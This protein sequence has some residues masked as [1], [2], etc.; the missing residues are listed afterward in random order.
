MCIC[1]FKVQFFFKLNKNLPTSFKMTYV[2][3]IWIMILL[4][5]S[6]TD[7]SSHRLAPNC[8]RSV[9][10]PK[11]VF[12]SSIRGFTTMRY[13][14]LRFTY[15]LTYRTRFMEKML[16]KKRRIAINFYKSICILNT[17]YFDVFCIFYNYI[18]LK[19]IYPALHSK[20]RRIDFSAFD[21]YIL[22]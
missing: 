11:A 10:N 13:I 21:A 9:L 19:C 15:L 4:A 16:Q 5:N 6:K 18:L 1:I 8:W 2:R 12:S 17:K 20:G 14:S 22:T 3:K 7:C